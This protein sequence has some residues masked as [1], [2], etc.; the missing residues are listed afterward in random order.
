[1]QPQ[2]HGLARFHKAGGAAGCVELGAL[3]RF[4]WKA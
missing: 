2:P 3:C 1:M 4:E